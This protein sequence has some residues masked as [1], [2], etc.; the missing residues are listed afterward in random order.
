MMPCPKDVSNIFFI[1]FFYQN[2]YEYVGV[3]NIEK[4][5]NGEQAINKYDK[6]LN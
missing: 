4:G 2:C 1:I 6:P 5:L 3:S